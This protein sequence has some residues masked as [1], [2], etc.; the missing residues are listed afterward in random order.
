MEKFLLNTIVITLH[1][2]NNKKETT[3]AKNNIQRQKKNKKKIENKRK[4]IQGNI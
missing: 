2:K 4:N 1:T 3:K